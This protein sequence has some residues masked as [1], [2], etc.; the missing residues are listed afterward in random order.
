MQASRL[1]LALATGAWVLPDAGDIAVFRPRLGDDLGALP[2]SRIVVLTGFC[3]D[4]DHFSGL[5]YRTASAAPYATALVCL[6]RA[7]ADAQA[8]LA[9]ANVVPGGIIA[10]D[11]Q[12]TDGIDSV[13]KDCRA[14]GLRVSDPLSKAHG[15]FATVESA[16]AL[17]AWA[18]RDLVV[19]GDFITRPGVFSADGADRGSALLAAALPVD[20]P[21]RVGD[22]GAGWG[23]LSRAVLA[24]PGVR[25][26][27]VVEAERVA[28]DCARA[29]LSDPR[30]AFHWADAT[31]FRPDRP[32]G[33]V[34]MN[35][36]FHTG[37]EADPG[38][39]LAFLRAAH[40]GL[41]P[42]GVLWMVANRHLP[43][44]KTLHELFREVT[45]IGRD[46]AFRVIRAA[47]PVR[48][49]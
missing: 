32:W 26:L 4:H 17:S 23:Y 18:A 35:P 20:L 11:G 42:D 28:L 2:K 48:S 37:R 13:L 16:P 24:R 41:A 40:R 9:N 21:A 5:G 38:L 44:D 47:Y 49:R 33:S 6:P 19:E 30:A 31:R 15:K 12:K 34:V 36:P 22:L 45:D 46:P 10:V 14:L 8:L 29:N 7:K 39:G 3:P 1:Q 43:Y 27:D 25:H